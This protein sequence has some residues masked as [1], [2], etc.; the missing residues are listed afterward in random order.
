MSTSELPTMRQTNRTLTKSL[1]ACNTLPQA[2][3]CPALQPAPHKTG[4][5]LLLLLAT[6]NTTMEYTGNASAGSYRHQTL[7]HE[8]AE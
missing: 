4:A 6:C 1:R 3:Y 2:E 8:Q 5:R 7:A